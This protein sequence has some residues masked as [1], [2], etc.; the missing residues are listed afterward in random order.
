MSKLSSVTRRSFVKGAGAAAAIATVAGAG[1]AHAGEYEW[2]LEA[3]V[4]VVG[5]GGA[6]AC[7]SIAAA[8]AGAQVLLIE[9]NAEA[10]HL[11]NTLMSGGIFHAAEPDGDPEALRQYLRAMFSGENLETKFEGELSP[12]YVDGIVEKFAEYMPYN[13]DFMLSL[14]P[15]YHI[16][17]RG[18]AAFPQFPGA[19]A[20][21]YVSYNSSYG[22]AATGPK[23]PTIDMPKED[24]AA[25]LAFFNC[26]RTG[27]EARSGA[28]QVL[29]E[30]PAKRLITDESGQVIGVVAEQGDTQVNIKAKRGVVLTCGGYEYNV[31]MRRAFL[32][33]QGITGWAFYGTPSNTGDG[34]RMGCEIGAQLAKVGKAASRLIWSCPDVQVNGCNVGSIT[35][36]VGG[37]GTIVVNAEGRRFMNEALITKDPSR[38]FS[39]KNAVHMDIEKLEFPNTPSYMII[40]EIKRLSGSLV[41]LTLSTCGFGLID[42]DPE[43]QNA[44]DNGWLIK[45]DTIE[46]L[47]EKI[48]DTHEPNCGRMDPEVLAQTMA[49]YQQMVDTGVDEEFGRTSKTKD[50]ITGEEVDAGFQP[51]S[52]PPFYALPLVAGG[53]NTKGGLQCDGERHVMNWF[54]EPI[55]RLYS[56]GEISSVFK[57]VYQGGGNLTECITCGRIAGQNAAVETPWDAE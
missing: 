46:E 18:G 52:E 7:A 1:I 47:A 28:I 53:P 22:D 40:D 45:A 9:K 5:F 24:T 32:E 44:V 23:Y 39:Y 21:G 13:D 26:L 3:D 29:W 41:N 50:P 25:G 38:Y 16:I 57:F 17:Y 14:D 42:W 19:D 10:S 12:E 8:D 30:T 35:D 48:R 55:A 51:I 49:T 2:G 31:E 27:V 15:D 20:A 36:S 34:I 4:V 37:A 43:N 11:C 6:G 56:A 54:N 33:G